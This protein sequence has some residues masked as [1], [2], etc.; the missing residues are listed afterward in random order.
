LISILCEALQL[1]GAFN[2]ITPDVLH[3]YV[4][5]LGYVLEKE[6]YFLMVGSS[7]DYKDLQSINLLVEQERKNL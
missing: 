1:L 2:V 7:P 5:S 3:R 4:E 6:R